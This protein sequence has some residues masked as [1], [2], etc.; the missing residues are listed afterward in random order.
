MARSK[1]QEIKRRTKKGET[2]RI[3][4]G[5]WRLCT[6]IGC[7]DFD[8]AEY[9]RFIIKNGLFTTFYELMENWLLNTPPSRPLPSWMPFGDI[10]RANGRTDFWEQSER[11]RKEVVDDFIDLKDRARK[12]S[13]DGKTILDKIDL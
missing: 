1:E 9:N 2:W 3:V 12:A 7:D 5:H 13:S 8:R 4:D 10:P 6:D 11:E